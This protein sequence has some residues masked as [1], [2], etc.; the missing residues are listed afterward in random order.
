[1]KDMNIRGHVTFRKGDKVYSVNRKQSGYVISPLTESG[2]EYLAIR[3]DDREVF[4]YR[5]PEDIPN[6]IYPLHIYEGLMKRKIIVEDAP[7]IRSRYEYMRF[8]V[9]TDAIDYEYSGTVRIGS[10]VQKKKAPERGHVRTDV[11]QDIL[12]IFEE[13]Q[14]FAGKPDWYLEQYSPVS[15]YLDYLGD[16]D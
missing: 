13:A 6:N 11:D 16:D 10:T 15:D 4:L 1:M 14:S 3:Y 2:S 7:L 8:Y 12:D 5:V 9:R